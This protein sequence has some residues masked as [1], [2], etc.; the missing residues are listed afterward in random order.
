MSRYTEYDETSLFVISKLTAV[1]AGTKRAM[2]VTNEMMQIVMMMCRGQ[3]KGFPR[4]RTCSSMHL[5]MGK[6]MSGTVR[7]MAK[8]YNTRTTLVNVSP[9]CFLAELAYLGRGGGERE[10]Q[11]PVSFAHSATV[12]RPRYRIHSLG[13]PVFGIV[14]TPQVAKVW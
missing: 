9:P 3:E 6:Q 1:M 7:T 11:D 5:R 13:L 8:A 2:M 12:L 10:Q 14:H 4:K